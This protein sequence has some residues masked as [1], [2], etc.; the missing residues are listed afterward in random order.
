M[1]TKIPFFG[2]KFL[3][4]FEVVTFWGLLYTRFF[5]ELALTSI[6]SLCPSVPSW[7]GDFWL[8]IVLLILAY[9]S[10]YP[11]M[12]IIFILPRPTSASLRRS[13]VVRRGSREGREGRE[14]REGREG[15][16]GRDSALLREDRE[17]QSREQQLLAQRGEQ[18]AYV[19]HQLISKYNCMSSSALY[20]C[21]IYN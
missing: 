19:A 13:S 1:K 20:E 15:W 2:R 16:E 5:T 11:V 7:T 3:G 8:K 21:Q 4:N 9:L 12:L 10:Y 6:Q 18:A 17:A 14:V